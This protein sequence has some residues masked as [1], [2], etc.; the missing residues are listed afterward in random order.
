MTL[1][2]YHEEAILVILSAPN[3]TEVKN[4]DFVEPLTKVKQS[5]YSESLAYIPCVL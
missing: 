3:D 5:L 2:Q 1:H 4:S